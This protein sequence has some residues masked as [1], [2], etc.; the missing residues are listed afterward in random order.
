MGRGDIV[1]KTVVLFPERKVSLTAN[2][3]EISF[4]T[5]SDNDLTVIPVCGVDR[6]MDKR[7]RWGEAT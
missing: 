2:P 3:L 1:M 6:L 7:P 5:T 4:Q